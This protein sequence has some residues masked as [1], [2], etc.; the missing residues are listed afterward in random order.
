VVGGLRERA[1]TDPT[2]PRMIE[3][4]GALSLGSDRFRTLWARAEVGYRSDGTGRFRHPQVG[5]L[6]LRKEKLDI[7]RTDGMQLVIYHA[8][9]GSETAQAL[10]L[11]GSLA[12]TREREYERE[13]EYEREREYDRERAESERARC[14]QNQGEQATEDLGRDRDTE[15]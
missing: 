7:A 10:A 13:H 15:A 11:L 4:V 1:G 3:L 14:E 6:L 12:A 9:P 2:D 5:E 8:E